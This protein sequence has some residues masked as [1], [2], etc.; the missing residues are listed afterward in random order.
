MAIE[1]Y[2]TI[3]DRM[4]K[5]VKPND[6]KVDYLH[7]SNFAGLL[8]EITIDLKMP[9]EQKPHPKMTEECKPP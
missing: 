9:C 7:D 8:D 5:Q 6:D 1:R 2:K 4:S 3:I